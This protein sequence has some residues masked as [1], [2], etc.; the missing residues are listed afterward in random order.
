MRWTDQD[1]DEMI[2][3]ELRALNGK[4]AKLKQCLRELAVLVGDRIEG[5]HEDCEDG[6]LV[7]H[8]EL[9]KKIAEAHELA[10]A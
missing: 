9:E 8:R 4:I 2:K 3:E 7:E 1:A 10:D 6:K 5:V